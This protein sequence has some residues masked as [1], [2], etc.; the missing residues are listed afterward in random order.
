MSAVVVYKRKPWTKEEVKVPNLAIMR[1]GSNVSEVGSDIG[2]VQQRASRA[3]R[4]GEKNIKA[5]ASSLRGHQPPTRNAP[6]F[7]MFKF[8]F[9][10]AA[11]CVVVHAAPIGLFSRSL[12]SHGNTD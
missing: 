9:F 5:G 11:L 12:S 1:R 6:G 2:H 4:E 3:L 10:V 7:A 8:K